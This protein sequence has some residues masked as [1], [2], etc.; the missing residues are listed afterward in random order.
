MAGIEILGAVASAVQLIDICLRVTES[1]STFSSR[2]IDVPIS[3]S[4]Q[5]AHLAQL[6]QVMRLIQ[7]C[8]SL[9][10]AVLVPI[11][12]SVTI[13]V[14]ALQ[15]IL[16]KVTPE[17]TAGKAKIYWKSL[18]C[19]FKEKKILSVC[20]RLEEEKNTLTLCIAAIDSDLLHSVKL[21]VIKV[22]CMADDV[23]K[24]LPAIRDTAQG[25]TSILEDMPKLTS[26]MKDLH[27]GIPDIVSKVTTIE[28]NI[29]VIAHKVDF[30]YNEI[31]NLRKTM[32]RLE[33]SD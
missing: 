18:D 7:H 17:A 26:Q 21:G 4:K 24:E 2:V 20:R 12:T 16:G 22:Q 32:E 13:E 23:F 8:P 15:D 25:V 14:R 31:P 19:A 5:K 6:V 27:Y 9:K 10:T 28:N 11:L 3:I 30:I 33:V 1:L 29:P